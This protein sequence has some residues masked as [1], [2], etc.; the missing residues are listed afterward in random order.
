MRSPRARMDGMVDSE[1]L[2]KRLSG[3]RT[4]GGGTADLSCDLVAVGFR[5]NRPKNVRVCP[6]THSA[7]SMHSDGQSCAH[8]RYGRNGQ[9]APHCVSQWRSKG[10]ATATATA[11]VTAA[12]TA[13]AAAAAAAMEN[14]LLS[15]VTRTHAT[16]PTTQCPV[17][18]PYETN[19]RAAPSSPGGPHDYISTTSRR[20]AGGGRLRLRQ[21]AGVSL[22]LCVG[23]SK[24]SSRA[25]Q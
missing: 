1:S 4:G 25:S 14:H 15:Q 20:V 6:R 7:T 11:A 5:L 12:V 13:A 22:W 3:A 17:T 9:G 24:A 16:D 23:E 8:E 21:Q 19:G 2:W 10:I 18:R